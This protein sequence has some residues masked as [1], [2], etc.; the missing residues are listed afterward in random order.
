MSKTC[1]LDKLVLAIQKELHTINFL[2]SVFFINERN[3]CLAQHAVTNRI[4]KAHSLCKP[5]I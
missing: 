5:N 1:D 3:F 2:G 4:F